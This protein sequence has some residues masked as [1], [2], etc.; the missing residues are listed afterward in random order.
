[1]EKMEKYGLEENQ[2]A[3]VDLAFSEKVEERKLVGEIYAQI[4]KKDI[5]Q[6][7]ALEA[8]ELRL[9]AVKIKSGIS[10]V[11]KTQKEFALAFG[12]Y[13]DAW[14]RKETEPIQQMIDG[15]I[16]IEKFEEI[17]EQKRIAALQTERELAIGEFLI[18]GSTKQ[19][20]EM[21]D[22]VWKAYFEAKKKEHETI[23]QNKAIEDAEREAKAELEAQEKA[24]ALAENARLKKEAK[25]RDEKEA[26][27]RAEREAAQRIQD[28]KIAKEKAEQKRIQDEERKKREVLE[29]ELKA[30]KDAEEQAKK[31]EAAKVQLELNKGDEQKVLDLVNDL[32]ALKYKYTFKSK[33]NNKMMN[34][35]EVLLERIVEHINE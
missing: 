30:K 32:N 11:H 19:L 34:D 4:I 14:K 15:L 3:N 8:R 5:T 22:E 29:K 27:E 2:I 28:E 31:D 23:I 33:K 25:E 7:V 17:R 12:K 6:E 20:G 18:D 13:C 26:K 24:K 10:S 16:E 1:M 9:K 35:V 21:D